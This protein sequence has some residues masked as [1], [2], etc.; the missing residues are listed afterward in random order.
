MKKRLLTKDYER[1]VL[2]SFIIPQSDWYK[3]YLNLIESNYQYNTDI[4]EQIEQVLNK[5]IE[6]YKSKVYGGLVPIEN[7]NGK[8]EYVDI[9]QIFEVDENGKKTA[10]NLEETLF[11]FQL[12]LE[13]V[14][15]TKSM[16]RRYFEKQ[17]ET[18][19]TIK[20][21]ISLKNNLIEFEN[22]LPEPIRKYFKENPMPEG[23]ELIDLQKR[24]EIIGQVPELLKQQKEA[25][26]NIINEN[27]Q[28]DPRKYTIEQYSLAYIFDCNIIGESIPYGS[29]TE[30]EKIGKKRNIGEYSPNTFYKR[31][32]WILKNHQLNSETD[33]VKIA[34]ENWKEIILELSKYPEELQ[35]YLQSKQL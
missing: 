28:D 3:Y 18:I 1:I 10:I 19:G 4:A 8:I 16:N 13:G 23:F 7:E 5:W 25:L 30:L 2:E 6:F 26:Q 9:N 21:A 35:K 33:L 11:P 34:G 32:S 14:I 17:I 15:H 12:E 24:V 29:K 22:N 27:N 20:D 31:V